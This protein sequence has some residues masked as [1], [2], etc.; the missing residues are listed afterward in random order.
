MPEHQLQAAAL[1]VRDG[2]ICLVTSRRKARWVIPKG[3]ID[4]GHTPVQAAETEAWEEA[5]LVGILNPT[6][7]GSYGYEKLGRS[8]LVSVFAMEVTV[9]HPTWPEDGQRRRE[10]VAIDEALARIDEPG[11]RAIVRLATA[12]GGPLGPPVLA[13]NFATDTVRERIDTARGRG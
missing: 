10:W 2:R 9:E 1:P 7:L 12:I 4:R 11:L 6:P 3:R 8:H 5:G 13:P